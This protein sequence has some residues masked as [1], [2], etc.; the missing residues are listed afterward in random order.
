MS[1][2]ERECPSCALPV[3]GTPEEC[4]YCGYEFPR[5]KTSVKWMAWVLALIL[6]W[7]AI[8]GLMWLIE[9]LGG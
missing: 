8:E 5:Q 3:E 7:P 1:P 6:L 9:A 4:P 2:R